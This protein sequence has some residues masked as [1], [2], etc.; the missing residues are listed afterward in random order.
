VDGLPVLACQTVVAD[1]RQAIRIE[2]LGG[3][4]VIRDLI[5]DMGPFLDRW[6]R[7]TPFLVPRPD[8]AEPAT[9]PPASAERRTIDS[10]LDCITCGACF[11]ACGMA[12]DG[13]PFLG[14]AALTRA[15]VLVAD[16]RDEAVHAR[17]VAVAGDGGIDFCHGIGACTAVC[18]KGLDPAAAIRRLRRWRVRPP[19]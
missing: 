8:D 13:S 15:L 9:I 10:D 14:P 11:A 19:R 16:S 3:L 5:V 1:E 7:V 4:P 6:A 17:L 18:P 2:P 12:S